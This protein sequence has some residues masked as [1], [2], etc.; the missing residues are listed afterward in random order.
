[1]HT[2]LAPNTKVRTVE[3]AALK[4]HESFDLSKHLVLLLTKIGLL[5]VSRN[6]GNC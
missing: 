2:R 5:N 4:H 1:M 6:T 3:R